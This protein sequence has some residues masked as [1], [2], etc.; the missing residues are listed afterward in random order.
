MKCNLSVV[1]YQACI[2]A[3]LAVGGAT[4]AHAQSTPEM[5]EILNRL[6]RLETD[7]QALM[8]ELR[9]L[10][11]ELAARAGVSDGGAQTAGQPAPAA[12][13]TTDERLDLQQNRID[14]LAQTKVEASEKFP[15]RVTGM[16]LF[17]AY[18]N[19][20]NNNNTEN[21]T[22]ASLDPADATGGATL[23][24]STLGLLFNGPQTF[25][26][27]KV[28]G[29][30]YMDFFGGSTS[31][32]NHLVR[33]RTA[34][35][36]LDWAN[37]SIMAGQEK[38]LISQ[39]DPNSLAQVGVSPLTGAGNLW[40]WQPQIRLEQRF[41]LGDDTGL[42]VQAAAVQTSQLNA[43]VDPNEYAPSTSGLPPEDSNPAGEARVELWQRW[44]ETGRL[45]I[46]G[47]FHVNRNHVAGFSLPTDIY[48][49]DWFFRP[50]GKV[51][52][53]GMFYHGRNVAVLGAL[54]QGFTVLNGHWLSVPSTGGWAQ[55]RFP[56]TSRLSFNVFGG[57]QDDRNSDLVF[58]NIVK[59]QAYFSNVM[60]RFAPNVMVSLEGGQVRTT[61]A[62]AGNRLNDH[63]D[64][65]IAYLF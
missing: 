54:R 55:L 62:G 60:Y 16:A 14:E 1:C 26:G 28:S 61:Y 5:R 17:N 19:G 22:I 44:S 51:E 10:R 41:S 65:A 4:P 35:L 40:L 42:R 46:A 24:Q 63:Y 58:G 3:V 11:Q 36:S 31:S 34:A 49:L 25:L 7:N 27:G 21:P 39:R 43:S 59:N 56:L 45:E 33:L 6:D 37:T 29:Y 9:L 18:V 48:S 8:Q 52:F 30:L 23:R 64:L 20:R 2:A 13:E 32:L 57:E 15:V 12:R 50:V 38:P 47:G 53:S